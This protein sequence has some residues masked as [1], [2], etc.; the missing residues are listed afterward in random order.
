MNLTLLGE[1]T[2]LKLNKKLP[3]NVSNAVKLTKI[4][5]VN[6]ESVKLELLKDIRSRLDS[7]IFLI[8]ELPKLHYHKCTQWLKSMGYIIIGNELSN[9]VAVSWI[10][11]RSSKLKFTEELILTKISAIPKE[12]LTWIDEPRNW[13]Q[14]KLTTDKKQNFNN[15]VSL[16]NKMP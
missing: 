5:Q 13:I 2:R 3:N 14:P 7:D 8:A 6:F 16:I 15:L 9:K 11:S 12:E 1:L 10:G 4:T